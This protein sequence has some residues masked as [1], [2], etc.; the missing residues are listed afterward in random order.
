MKV[1][2]LRP[3]VL[4]RP[5]ISRYWSW[6]AESVLPPLLPGCGGELFLYYREPV[7]L[8]LSN[9]QQ[10]SQ[11][12]S[13]LLLPRNHSFRFHS[14]RPASFIAVRFRTGALRHFCPQPEYELIDSCS[15]A[16]DIW[17]LAGA[18]FEQQIGEAANLAERVQLIERF[19]SARLQR[20]HKQQ[21]RWLDTVTQQLY[22]RQRSISLSDLIE[23]YS[24]STRHFQRV[25][26]QNFGVSP[27]HLQRIIRIEAV[28]RHLL[29]NR[30]KDYLDTA[31]AHGYYDQSHFIKDCRCF[32]GETPSR[33]F[34]ENNF[35]AHFYNPSL[36]Y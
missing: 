1:S 24:L 3:G 8:T 14:I 36:A 35:R 23:Q 25:F 19:L 31:L 29:L 30:Q 4:L 20:H 10:Y 21:H 15:S 32:I 12:I 11:L 13:M 27:K 33:F 7:D 5:Y 6:Q 34:Q 17:G 28:T 9:Q 2:N 16:A 26:K 22:Y 18:R